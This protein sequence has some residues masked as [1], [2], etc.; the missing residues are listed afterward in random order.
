MFAKQ[1]WQHQKLASVALRDDGTQVGEEKD[2]ISKLSMTYKYLRQGIG[3]AVVV[4]ERGVKKAKL[5]VRLGSKD[6]H[7]VYEAEC[8]ALL[9]GLHAISKWRT[10]QIVLNADNQAAIQAIS[11]ISP[12]P[13][14]YLLMCCQIVWHCVLYMGQCKSRCSTVLL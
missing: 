3:A 4:Y 10:Q 2:C 5:Q 11:S 1:V 13:G 14:R 8:A 6:T 12:A 7:T 9:L